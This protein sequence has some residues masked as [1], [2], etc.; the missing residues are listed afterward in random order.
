MTMS[1]RVLAS[2]E[3]ISISRRDRS[4]PWG[5]WSASLLLVVLLTVAT[6]W[7]SKAVPGWN[8]QLRVIEFPV[9]AVLLGLLASGVLSLLGI[10]ER[11]AAYFR[12]E[13]FLK[14]GLVLLG[15]TINLAEIVAFGAKGLV[16]A[17]ILITSVF[18]FTWFLARW[19]GVEEKLRA[20]LAASV[21][22]CGV[23]AAITAAGAVLAKKEQ[24]VYVTGLVILFALPLMF[25]QPAAAVWLGLSPNV[26]GAWI[27]GN[28]DTTAAVVGAGTIHSQQ[29]LK[30]ASI[31]K[32]SQNALIGVVAFLLAL[33][34][35]VVVERKPGR[36]PSAGQ[37]WERFPKFVLGFILAS[38][39]VTVALSN[40]WLAASATRDLRHLREWF[41]MAAF[42]SIGFGLSFRGLR[43]AGWRPIGVYALATLFNTGVALGVASVI[44]R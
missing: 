40:G 34:W 24:L 9:Y 12:T 21:A 30:V 28:I 44:F 16:Q 8:K 2:G 27:G 11:L 29:A 41:F 6:W 33:Y 25:L 39:V 3:A 22:I 43:E 5:W 37:I 20:L 31:T 1:D 13:F 38:I 15:A 14:T 26:A 10:R 7:L 19:L 32:I 35:V 18:F 17:V 23:S 42:L 4:R 36:R